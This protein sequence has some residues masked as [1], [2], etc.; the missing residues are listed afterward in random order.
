[1]AKIVQTHGKY[2]KMFPMTFHCELC[3]CIFDCDY[4]SDVGIYLSLSE[5]FARTRCPECEAWVRNSIGL[6]ELEI[7]S[8][9][10]DEE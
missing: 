2:H 3:E 5:V 6:I 4:I 7:E 10:E 8:E 1:M 9:Q